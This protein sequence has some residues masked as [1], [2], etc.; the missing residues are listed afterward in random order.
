ML[1]KMCFE[2]IKRVNAVFFIKVDRK[3]I[4]REVC[5]K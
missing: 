5:L 3:K 4:S 1:Y 2:R